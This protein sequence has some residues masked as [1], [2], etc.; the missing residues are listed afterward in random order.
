MSSSNRWLV[1]L[2]L[3]IF[4]IAPLLGPQIV[5]AIY[6]VLVVA[7]VGYRVWQNYRPD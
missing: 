6:A 1:G 3:W 4:I 7:F 5:I 2:M